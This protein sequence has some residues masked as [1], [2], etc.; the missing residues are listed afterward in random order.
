LNF[1]LIIA[2]A[3]TIS[4]TSTSDTDGGVITITGTNFVPAGVDPGM[5]YFLLILFGQSF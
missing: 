3:P 5:N 2:A 4:S 1:E